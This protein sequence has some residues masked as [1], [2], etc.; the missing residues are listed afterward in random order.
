LYKKAFRALSA[1]EFFFSKQWIFLSKNSD[2]IWS[3]MSTKDRQIF[4]FNVRDINWRAY[5]ETYILGTRRFILK[6]DIS[7]LPEAKKNV[8]K[9]INQHKLWTNLLCFNRF[10]CLFRLYLLRNCLHIFLF[11]VSLI[12]FSSVF[13]LMKLFLRK[14]NIATSDL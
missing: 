14:R 5:F 13:N 6:D 8:T 1:F 3:K 11:A 12:G 10:S 4:Y 7:T 2:G 9:Y